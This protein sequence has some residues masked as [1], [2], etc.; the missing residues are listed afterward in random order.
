MVFNWFRRQHNDS[1]NTPSDQ[2]QEET[3]PAKEPQPKPA[4]TSTPTAETTP[5]TTADLLAFAKAAYKNIQQKQQVEVV[6]TLPDP[7]DTLAP[8]I[9]PETAETATA[10]ITEPEATN[11]TVETAQPEVIQAASEEEITEDSSVAAIAEQPDVS[12]TELTASE[13]E[14]TPSEPLATP[15]A[16]QPT[17]PANLSFLERAAAER[18]AKLEQLIATA[19]EVPEPEVVQPVATTSETQEEIPGLVFDDGFV[20]SAKVLAAQGRSAEDVS[21]EEITWLKKLR[22]GLDKTRRSILNQLKAIVGQGPLNSAA[23]TEIEALLLQAD[24]GVEATDFIINALQTKLREEVTAPEEAIAFLKKI[25]RDMLDAPSKTSQKTTFTPEK[26]TLN[27]WLITGVNGAGKTTTIGKIAHLGQKSGYKCL[28][29]AAD[30]FRAAAVEQVKVWGSR[31]GVDV[32]ANPGKNTDPAAVV[33]D[34]IAAAQA[35]QTELLLVDTA[36]RLQNKKNL[37]DELGKIRR[38]IDKKAPDAKVESLLVL[39]ATLGQNGL[40][41]AEVFSQAAQLSGVVLTKLDGTAKGGVALAVV[42]QLGLPIRFIGAGEGIEDLR[43]FSSYEFVE[44]L[45]SG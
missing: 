27:I 44:A 43:P 28:I 19:I 42:Q 45:L 24:V 16:T 15:E 35:R 25:L 7:A 26:E 6:E 3:P 20:W 41:Q 36:G 2:K 8:S 21:I 31:S 11:T 4:E 29:G 22:Q 32:I 1:S 14:P 23:V 13:V 38:I 18:Q 40:R 12:T 30:T 5:D 39:D 37:M 33:F 10:E 17:A 9:E 34:A